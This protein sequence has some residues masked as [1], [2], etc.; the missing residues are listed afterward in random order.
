MCGVYSL[1]YGVVSLIPFQREY[2]GPVLF[3]AHVDLSHCRN[4]GAS[5]IL[6]DLFNTSIRLRACTGASLLGLLNPVLK[7]QYLSCAMICNNC[8]LSD[9]HPVE[10]CGVCNFVK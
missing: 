4:S 10:N 9:F 7:W 5:V 2:K 1:I 8:R 3:F 6:S